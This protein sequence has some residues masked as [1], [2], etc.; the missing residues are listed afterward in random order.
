MPVVVQSCCLDDTGALAVRLA[1]ALRPGDVLALDA[2]MG[3]GKTTLVRFLAD[4]LGVP[5]GMVASPTF[6]IA[7]EY[8]L[9]G[10]R[11]LMH[12]DAYRLHG[13]EDAES[14]AWDRLLDPR[15]ILVVE[16]PDRVA[17]LLPE[18]RVST[19]RIEPTAPEA[20]RFTIEGALAERLDL[21]MS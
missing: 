17:G 12:M 18:D 21:P 13:P 6:V 11:S 5:A 20:R 19:I 7:H 8:P 15:H 9:G 14:L 16:W 2:P 1:G 10:G 4:A 3:A